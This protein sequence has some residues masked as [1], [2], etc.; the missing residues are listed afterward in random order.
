MQ[1]QATRTSVTCNQSLLIAGI[2][3]VVGFLTTTLA[4]PRVLVHLPLQN[5][6][7]NVLHT[8]RST[9]A[10]FFFWVG[11]PWY[12]KPLLGVLSDTFP[13][14]GSRRKSYIVIGALAAAGAWSF[15]GAATHSYSELMIICMI[16]NLATV[17]ASTA[18]GGY[19]VEAARATS[20]AGRLTSLRNFAMQFSY[21]VAGPA[22]GLLGTLA[23][24]WTALACAGTAFLIVPVAWWLVRESSYQPAPGGSMHDMGRALRVMV[25]ARTVWAA[26]AVAALFYVA[27]GLNT[28]LFYLQQNT[29][30]LNTQDQGH[31]VF[32]NAGGG[33]LA[34]AL[35]GFFA[36]RRLPLRTLLRVCL[37]FSAVAPLGYLFYD[38]YV[39]AQ[40]IEAANGFGTALGEIAVMHLAVRATPIGSEAL[41]FAVLM[42][43]RNL[44]MWG[45]DW[46]G[47]ALIDSLH[48]PFDTVVYISAGTTLLV[49]PLA[50]VL[51]RVLINDS[52]N[53]RV[54]E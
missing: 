33:M 35:Y 19:M 15:L 40:T 54:D 50:L 27:P 17:V 48:V 24:G 53:K 11:L 44:F 1:S 39:H 34:A 16:A 41:G 32:L 31:L 38:S 2:V 8:D 47:S 12:I 43:V 10:A 3:I 45:S 4:Q 5:L 6:L 18:L 20:G 25:R 21:L 28:A 49:V 7:K 22:G 36:A 42:A 29:L 23:L 13:I 14:F 51:P 37:V 46:L 52:D 9:N 30:H 26:A